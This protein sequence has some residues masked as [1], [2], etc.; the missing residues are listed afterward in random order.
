[1]GCAV[2]IMDEW[3]SIWSQNGSFNFVCA[4]WKNGF[5]P[6]ILS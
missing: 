4:Y 5:Y 2:L 1:M 6:E 3:L